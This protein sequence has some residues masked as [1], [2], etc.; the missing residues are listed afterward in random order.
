MAFFVDVTHSIFPDV[1]KYLLRSR[2]DK[3][4]VNVQNSS[5]KTLLHIAAATNNLPLCKVIINHDCD[6]NALMKHAVSSICC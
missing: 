6:K 4:A 2:N 1:V 3:D 5:G